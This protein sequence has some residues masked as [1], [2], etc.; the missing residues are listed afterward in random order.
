LFDFFRHNFFSVNGRRIISRSNTRWHYQ[1]AI[2]LDGAGFSGHNG[3][4]MSSSRFAFCVLICLALALPAWAGHTLAPQEQKILAAWLSG[5]PTFSA[6]T[7]KDCDCSEDIQEMRVGSGGVWRPVP[8]YHP[9][10]ATGDFNSDG[11]RDFAVVVIDKSKSIHPVTLLVFNGPFDADAVAPSF[12]ESGLD[13]SYMA[14]FFGPPRPRP[15]RLI[16][17]RFNSDNTLMLVPHG[18]TYQLR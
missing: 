17:G 4:I 1:Y 11:I 3:S 13:L 7:D 18:K 8:D 6:A 15:F 14:L 9:Y 5:H 16:M 2:D 12:V 10:V